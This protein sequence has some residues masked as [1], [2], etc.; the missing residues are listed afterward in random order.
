MKNKVRATR[1]TAKGNTNQAV[2]KG[3]KE[4]IPQIIQSKYWCFTWNNY[5]ST[6][7]GYLDKVF[8]SRGIGYFYGEEI[9]ESG[10]P[11]LQGFIE[12]QNKIRPTE[13]LLSKCIHW[14]K[15]KG[16]R[17]SN[18]TYCGK[19][20]LI[21]CSF[22]LKPL[23]IIKNLYKWQQDIENLYLNEDPD[24]RS[25]YWY[26]DKIGNKG[27]SS[28]CK[29]MSYHYKVLTIQG[30]KMADIINII[31][32]REHIGKMVLIDIPR[33]HGGK[34]SESAVECILNGQ[35]TNTKY[36][37]GDR[38]FNPPHVVI[39]SNSKPDVENMSKDRWKIIK[40]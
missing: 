35:I 11:H 6:I 33:K 29:Y 21:H 4:R 12:C 39:F 20:G 17:E 25:I 40:L 18:Q 19:E 14:E 24:G 5:E 32:N 15:R 16:D 26:Y 34:I 7:I 36:E 31:F 28:F 22:D 37:T 10:T 38:M 3:K 27:K 30:G 23:V 2:S 13:L 9:G 8:Q 1:E